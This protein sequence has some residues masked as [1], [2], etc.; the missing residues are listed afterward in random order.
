MIISF[1]IATFEWDVVRSS[2]AHDSTAS[3]LMLS[4]LP[5]IK[6]DASSAEKPP[7]SERL[8]LRYRKRVA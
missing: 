2:E 5:K 3:S 7:K 6:L 8:A 4:E 1:F